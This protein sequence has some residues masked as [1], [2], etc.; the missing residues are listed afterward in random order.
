M[1]SRLMGLLFLI[2]VLVSACGAVS[3]SDDLDILD[4]VIVPENKNFEYRGTWTV[5]S[6]EALNSAQRTSYADLGY[7]A[8]LEV[9]M[10]MYLDTEMISVGARSATRPTISLRLVDA[11][12]Y[13]SEEEYSLIKANLGSETSIRVLYISDQTSFSQEFV[14]MPDGS[15]LMTYDGLLIRFER[16]SPEVPEEILEA[17][18]QKAL[19]EQAQDSPG[20]ESVD[21]ALL[22]GLARPTVDIAGNDDYDYET[23]LIRRIPEK[24][25]QAYKAK[26]LLVPRPTGFWMVEKNRLETDNKVLQDRISAYPITS[27]NVDASYQLQE[28]ILREITFVNP[29]YIAFE[30][31][32][33]LFASHLEREIFELDALKSG[34][35]MNVG[36]I[37]GQDGLESFKKKIRDEWTSLSGQSDS[38]HMVMDE[39]NIGLERENGNWIFAS[40]IQVDH[41]SRVDYKSFILDLVPQVDIPVSNQLATTWSAIR[42]HSPNAIDAFTSDVSGLAIIQEPDEL[43]VYEMYGDHIAQKP[44]ISIPLSEK[45][46]IVM[47]EWAYNDYAGEWQATFER[48]QSINIQFQYYR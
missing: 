6:L 13:Y 37:A 47:A 43:F 1:K 9:G 15:L 41:E 29:N 14:A 42:T 2:T 40:S 34:A 38:K 11:Q 22:I 33:Y 21:T 20:R 32:N 16:S 27:K 24:A 8:A 26:D 10:P 35:Q 39:T 48:L 45:T 36:K 28:S 46:K 12:A 3:G 44:S 7:K 4:S 5:A 17:F 19:E 18:Q 23:I 31:Y 25:V 30:K